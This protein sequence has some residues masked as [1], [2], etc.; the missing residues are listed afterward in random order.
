MTLVR[1]AVLSP[2]MPRWYHVDAMETH[3]LVETL[4]YLILSYLIQIS[5][6]QAAAR[7]RHQEQT[8]KP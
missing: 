6:Q 7:T 1:L 4:P 2:S 3:M 5:K 8:L